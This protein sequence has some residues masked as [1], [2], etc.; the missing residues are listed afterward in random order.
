VVTT[1]KEAHRTIYK[2]NEKTAEE[3]LDDVQYGEKVKKL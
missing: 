3:M 2:H 1:L